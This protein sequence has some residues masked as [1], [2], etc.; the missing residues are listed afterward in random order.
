MNANRNEITYPQTGF[1]FLWL[2]PVVALLLLLWQ[3]PWSGLTYRQVG[4]RS[5]LQVVFQNE[6]LTVNP[7]W[8]AF[9]EIEPNLLKTIP[10]SMEQVNS[11]LNRERALGIIALAANDLA[12]ARQQL[13][14]RLEVAPNDVIAHFFLGEAYLR[15]GDTLAGIEHWEAAGAAAP[16]KRL[17]QDLIA[18]QAQAEA[19]AAL[20]A[21]RRLDPADEDTRRLAARL[22]LEQG[23][24]E[25]A[26]AI[27]QEIIALAPEKSSNYTSSGQILFD[28]G[29][30]EQAI[31]FFE[32]ALQRNPERP[33]WILEELGQS[34]AA[35]NQ[36]PEAIAA[37]EQ[38]IHA[39][40]ARHQLYVLMGQAQCQLGHAEEARFSFEQAIALGNKSKQVEQAV[41][42][43]ALHAAC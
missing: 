19:L 31:I 3:I 4:L 23:Q 7:R 6:S 34:Y 2:L 30:Y 17:S 5:F 26:L 10:G 9:I 18:R 22:W 21:V 8:P 24:P 20:E 33:R 1:R 38:A 13:L 35:L 25:H 36:W 28:A 40:P 11:Q 43:I 29:Q 42:Y 16:L 32:Q 12:E 27:Y 14:R 15:L 41:A 39:E 37:Y